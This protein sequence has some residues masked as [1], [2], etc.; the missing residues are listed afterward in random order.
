MKEVAEKKVD[1]KKEESFSARLE[2]C[3]DL[4]VLNKSGSNGIQ[5]IEKEATFASPETIK[6]C[7]F[8]IKTGVG[9]WGKGLEGFQAWWKKDDL[10]C[11]GYSDQLV[12]RFSAGS[13]WRGRR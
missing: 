1:H 13:V 3:R 5:S 4:G 9:G 12:D 6:K 10:K 8:G 7:V 2:S 11:V